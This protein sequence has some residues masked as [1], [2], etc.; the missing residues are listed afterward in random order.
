MNAQNKQALIAI[1][2]GGFLGLWFGHSVEKYGYLPEPQG[3]FIFSIITEEIGF[4]GASVIICVYLYIIY[5]GFMIAIFCEDLFGKYT[6]FGITVWIF[7]QMIINVSVNLSIFPNTGITLPFVSYGGSSLLMML[8]AGGI[9]LS[10]SR[11][12]DP[13]KKNLTN[14]FYLYAG[15]KPRR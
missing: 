15:K 6:A 13:T 5:R 2:S 11:E 10:I 1:G 12:V 14:I 9:L 4:I 7:W 8:I 3:D